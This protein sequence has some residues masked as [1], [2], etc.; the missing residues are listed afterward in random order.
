MHWVKIPTSPKSTSVRPFAPSR[1]YY[2]DDD[3]FIPVAIIRSSAEEARRAARITA[4]LDSA[5]RVTTHEKIV[6]WHRSMFASP[7]QQAHWVQQDAIS[8]VSSQ[9]GSAAWDGTTAAGGETN[10]AFTV[11]SSTMSLVLPPSSEVGQ[12][13][14]RRMAGAWWGKFRL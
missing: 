12:N 6:S 13:S 11:H 10:A 14:R 7:Q 2:V 1:P 3:E 5:K 9:D 4:H 8:P